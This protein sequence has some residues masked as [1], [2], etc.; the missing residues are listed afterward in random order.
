MGTLYIDRKD[1][2]LRLDGNALALYAA[3]QRQGLVPLAPIRRVVIAGNT[4]VETRVLSRLAEMNISVVFLSGRSLSYAG[5]LSGRLHNNGILRVR[6]YEASLGG[7]ALEFAAELVRR[8][9]AGQRD[10]LRS[11]ALQ[12]TDLETRLLRS[13][14]ILDGVIG[15]V[16]RCHTTSA[17]RG[18]EGGGS[19]AFFAAYRELFAPSLG[20]RKR[21]RRPPRDPVNALLSLTYTLLF[22]EALREVQVIGLDPAIGFLHDFEYG[23]DSLACDLVEPYRPLAEELVRRSFAERAF[24]REDFMRCAEGCFLGKSG[25]KRFYTLY[26]D[27]AASVRP[28]IRQ[29]AR[30][31][32][33]RLTDNEDKDT[34][35]RREQGDKAQ[36]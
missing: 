22:R 36:A 14:H 28:A 20:F 24:R 4:M 35:H 19:A 5:T 9:L 29:D 15:S 21:N 17:L 34:V 23:R 12:R 11:A 7:F 8:K 31:L 13:A 33:G 18:L 10:L 27:W 16:R 2:S 6:Q 32:A 3:G 30:K 1:V 26:E 25:R